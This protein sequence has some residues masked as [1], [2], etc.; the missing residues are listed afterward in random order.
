[1]NTNPSTCWK[2]YF[3]LHTYLEGMQWKKFQLRIPYP[4]VHINGLL[5]TAMYSE[6]TDGDERALSPFSVSWPQASWPSWWWWW[7][8]PAVAWLEFMWW[9]RLVGRTLLGP[10]LLLLL[11]LLQLPPWTGIIKWRSLVEWE[12]RP[13]NAAVGLTAW[14]LPQHA[15][16]SSSDAVSTAALP[17][18]L[19]PPP[20]LPRL[21]RRFRD[22]RRSHVLPAL[23]SQGWNCIASLHGKHRRY[24]LREIHD[25]RTY[26][27]EYKTGC[28]VQRSEIS[29]K[30]WHGSKEIDNVRIISEAFKF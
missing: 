14:L 24:S 16:E 27:S 12:W 20:V 17:L 19:L 30:H 22:S 2:N 29:V 26:P 3:Y 28:D 21:P 4:I 1:M 25:K 6:L 5:L 23:D 18:T 9:L 7:C 8:L 15:V 13:L 10:P 11:L